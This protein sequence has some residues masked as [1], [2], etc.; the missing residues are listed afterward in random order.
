MATVRTCAVRFRA[1]TRDLSR[2]FSLIIW[3]GSNFAAMV[4]FQN[5]HLMWVW[6]FAVVFCAGAWV[7]GGPARTNSGS[8]SGS[9]NSE[10]NTADKVQFS[11]SLFV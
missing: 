1:S 11:L 7:I 5:N 4:D 3:K 10:Q 6:C 8:S 2:Y 9:S